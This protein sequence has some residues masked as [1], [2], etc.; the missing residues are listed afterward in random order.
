LATVSLWSRKPPWPNISRCPKPPTL[1]LSVL[2][3]SYTSSGVPVKH[4]PL[5]ISCS[6]D[7]VVCSTGLPCRSLT[8]PPRLPPALSI[9]MLAASEL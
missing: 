1:S 8:N 2:I 9:A 7:A 3:W 4:V 5:S 6:I